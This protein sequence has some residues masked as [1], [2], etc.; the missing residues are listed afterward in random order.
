MM[1]FVVTFHDF[2][3]FS[4]SRSAEAFGSLTRPFN[5]LPRVDGNEPYQ[6]YLSRRLL[7]YGRP[8]IQQLPGG[9]MA[10]LLYSG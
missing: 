6:I 1:A 8:C 10:S 7:R 9:M 3:L 5:S 4:L 2:H